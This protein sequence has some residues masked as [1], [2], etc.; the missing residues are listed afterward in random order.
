ML[1]NDDSKRQVPRTLK[2]QCCTAVH[3][4]NVFDIQG[5]F[6]KIK[7]GPQ[8]RVGQKHCP[9]MFANQPNGPWE[10]AEF[11]CVLQDV[12]SDRFVAKQLKYLAKSFVWQGL[13]HDGHQSAI[14]VPR[15][16]RRHASRLTTISS[17]CNE[18]S[19]VRG[20]DVSEVSREIKSGK[21]GGRKRALI[22]RA[23][24]RRRN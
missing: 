9:P 14:L 6:L 19:A 3:F 4:G 20:K 5:T 13:R 1:V 17:N 18:N 21:P 12:E 22:G 7:R 10:F 24:T 2:I 16:P 23:G 11:G 15:L 8:T